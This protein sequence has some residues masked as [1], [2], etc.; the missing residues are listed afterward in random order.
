MWL[1]ADQLDPRRGTLTGEFDG[2]MN[3]IFRCEKF[4]V[5]IASQFRVKTINAN[6]KK[7]PA[8]RQRGFQSF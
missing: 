3:W 8:L 5:T 1:R 6:D 2:A 4:R 7:E